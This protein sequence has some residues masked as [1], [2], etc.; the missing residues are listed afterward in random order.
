MGDCHYLPKFELLTCLN[1]VNEQLA[2]QD[3]TEGF[4]NH[5]GAG[6]MFPIVQ[7]ILVLDQNTQTV[8]KGRKKK[9]KRQEFLQKVS[10]HSFCVSIWWHSH[11]SWSC[12][13]WRK[14]WQDNWWD[15]C[16]VHFALFDAC[17]CAIHAVNNLII[18]WER[19]CVCVRL[20][21]DTFALVKVKRF[22]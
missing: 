14:L 3:S 20:N 18:M 11:G 7:W 8:R 1:H 21:K 5:N 19:V 22:G 15:H 2:D 10:C 12:Y 16:C 9:K 13:R 17:T 6:L 4:S